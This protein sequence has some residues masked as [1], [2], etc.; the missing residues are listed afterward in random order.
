MVLEF[1]PDTHEYKLDGAFVPSVTGILRASGVV[2]FSG[3]RPDVLESARVRGVVVHQAIHY[4]NERDLDVDQFCRDYPDYA[5][6]LRAWLAFVSQRNFLPVFCEYRVASAR[7]RIAG[8]IDCLGILDGAGALIDFATG[9][10]A[11][12]AKDLQTAA[13]HGIAHDYAQH[14][15]RLG[16]FLSRYVVRRYAVALSRDGSFSVEAYRDPS[17][18]RTFLTLLSAEQIRTNRRG[19]A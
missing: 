9:N 13:Y 19:P 7:Y 10:P 2:D 11:D 6:Y 17:D 8:T 3:V 12:A 5:G 18:W 15:R 1:F 4:V 14:D 16:D